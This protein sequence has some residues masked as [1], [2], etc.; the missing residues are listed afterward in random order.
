VSTPPRAATATAL[1]HLFAMAEI[2]CLKRQADVA[3]RSVSIPGEWSPPVPGV[4]ITETMNHLADLG[5]KM[6]ADPASWSHEP[7]AF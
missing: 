7:P 6:G 4:F 2:S 1:K 5:T 3:V